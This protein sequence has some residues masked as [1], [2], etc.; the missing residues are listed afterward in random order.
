MERSYLGKSRICGLFSNALTTNTRKTIISHRN[1][2]NHTPPQ[3]LDAA[4]ESSVLQLLA[5]QQDEELII[6]TINAPS[7]LKYAA[8]KVELLKLAARRTR[9][10]GSGSNEC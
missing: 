7:M 5:N 2:V 3:S 9:G 8:G 4:G 6:A 1:A 10:Q